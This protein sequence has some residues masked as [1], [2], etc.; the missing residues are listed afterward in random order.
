M[1]TIKPTQP[2]M[3]GYAA[4]I[5]EI[6]DIWDT[7]ALTNNG[8]KVRKLQKRMK[9]YMGCQNADLFVNG[10]S[11]LMIAIQALGLQ[12]EVL[13]SPFTFVSTTNAI[14]Q[15]GL[16]PV[17]CDIDD[18]YNID[19]KKLEEHITDKTCA[20]VTPHIFGIPC[21][22]KEIEKIAS[23]HHLKVV[24]D[25]AQ[26][27][28]TRIAGE[29]IGKYGDVT[30]FSLHAIKVYNSIEG[31]LLTYADD[32]LHEKF[33][34]Y[35]NFGIAYHESGNDVEVCGMNAKMNEFQAA[36]GILGLDIV[37]K[38]IKLRKSLAQIYIDR[39]ARIEGVRTYPY[40]DGIDYNYAYFPIRIHQKAFG[41]SRDELFTALKEKGVITRKLYDTLCCD[42]SY[43]K[44]KNY[45]SDVNHARR[46][47]EEALDLPLYGTLLPEEAEHICQMIETIQ[48]EAKHVR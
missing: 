6:K 9:E 7:K 13:T 44:E 18:S 5:E 32:A 29:H 4:Y 22:V 10:H 20:I 26:A 34:L 2:S 12:G 33:E 41:L 8:P 40:A 31:G 23:K 45:A 25:G 1:N 35:R 46:I 16:T 27:F 47:A 15:N 43:Y 17:F 24:Y 11:A 42:Y 28:G 14:V 19:V 36:M 21:N 38:E 30:M 3:P 37:E 48:K 39:L